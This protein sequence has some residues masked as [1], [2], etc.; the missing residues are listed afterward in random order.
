MCSVMQPNRKII[1][2]LK[3]EHEL[4]LKKWVLQIGFFVSILVGE[5]VG[6]NKSKK[7]K[8]RVLFML[9]LRWHIYSTN[10]YSKTI[11][12]RRNHIIQ[13]H[14]IQ[15]MLDKMEKKRKYSFS[16]LVPFLSLCKARKQGNFL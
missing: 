2:W 3:I 13:T 16:A 5:N 4:G 8:S 15:R 14:E 9:L 6:F 11:P 7:I 1:I 12:T 10:A